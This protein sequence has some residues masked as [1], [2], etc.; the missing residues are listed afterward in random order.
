[1]LPILIA[2]ALAAGGSALANSS[3]SGKVSSARAGVSAAERAR[4]AAFDAE[5][6]KLNTQS[7]DRYQN[8]G[9]QQTAHAGTLA[10]MFRAPAATTA[11]PAVSLPATT[12]DI[13]AREMASKLGE[14]KAF[15]DNR[16]DALGNLRA[17]GDLFGGISRDQAHD[18]SLIGQIGGFKRGSADVASYELDAA[19]NAGNGMKLLGDILGGLSKVGLSAGLGGGAMPFA[20]AAPT[21][22]TNILPIAAR[23]APS[24][25]GAI[26]PAGAAS[27]ADAFR[28][29]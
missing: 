9:D 12:S 23:F 20:T 17:F 27:M 13:V 19:N 5:T 25:V 16:A 6:G 21:T 14:A 18:A 24:G 8:F 7:Q 11:Q 26:N 22:A 10:E 4:Q 2:S 1:M 29:Y 3:A 15:T 28:L